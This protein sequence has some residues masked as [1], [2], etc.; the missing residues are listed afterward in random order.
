MIV[1]QI[2][3]GQYKVSAVLDNVNYIYG[4]I[5]ILRGIP[6]FEGASPEEEPR[7]MSVSDLKELA[8]VME[9]LGKSL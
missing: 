2:A 6:F 4:Y 7:S 8:I 9:A 3:R 5:T 1:E